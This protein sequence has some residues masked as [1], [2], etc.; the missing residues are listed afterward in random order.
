MTPLWFARRRTDRKTASAAMLALMCVTG[1]GGGGNP[2]DNPPD[3]LNPATTGGQRLSFEYFQRCIYPILQAPLQVNIGGV[4]STNTCAG[5]GCHDNTN[6]TGGAFRVV[7]GATLVD[8]ANPANTAD[9]VKTTAMYVNFYSAQ[10][11]TV[12]GSPA[13]SKLL[14]KPLLQGVLHAGGQIFLD[15]LDPNARIFQYWISR[16]APQG[17]DEFS[18]TSNSMFTPANPQTGTCNTQ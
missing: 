14:N 9:V 11:S 3:V 6:S 8:L 12:V 5:S 13:Q 10:A 7:Q 4:V 15:N 2:L 17:Q 18:L 16:P 1:C